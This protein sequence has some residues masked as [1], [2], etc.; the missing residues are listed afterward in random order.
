[1]FEL[2]FY[3]C[4]WAW[5]DLKYKVLIKN[6]K[7]KPQNKTEEKART[8]AEESV[9]EG[10]DDDDDE[11]VEEDED[12]QAKAKFWSPRKAEAK[13]KVSQH[14]HVILKKLKQI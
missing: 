10:E 2:I 9:D 3:M 1:M 11:E 7:L 6:K 4:V 5:Q 14:F 12:H 13:K 8:E